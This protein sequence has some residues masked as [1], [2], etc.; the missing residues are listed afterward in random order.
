MV[1]SLIVI[2]F[3]LSTALFIYA[4]KSYVDVLRYKKEVELTMKET[5]D[6]IIQLQ[7]AI[8]DLHPKGK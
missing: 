8:E 2:A 1:T 5:Q 3:I 6:N 4:Y 7:V